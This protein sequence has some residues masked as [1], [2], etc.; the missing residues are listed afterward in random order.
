MEKKGIAT[1]R[2]NINREIKRHNH[3]VKIMKEQLHNL[4]DWIKDYLK[5]LTDQ[6]KIFSRESKKEMESE[7]KLFNLREYIEVYKMIQDEKQ[8]LL[9]G[10]AKQN[11]A[12]YDFKKFADAHFYLSS[13]Q[14]TETYTWWKSSAQMDDG[15]YLYQDESCW[16]YQSR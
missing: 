4:T 7:P 12:R 16:K 1:D 14:L 11:K 8:K 15:Q 10:Y 2:G 3:L 5:Y 13:N 9:K 6:F